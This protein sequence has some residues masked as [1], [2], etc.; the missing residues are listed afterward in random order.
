MPV[1][2]AISL[3]FRA[4]IAFTAWSLACHQSCGRCSDQP[5]LGRDTSRCTLSLS[6]TLWAS[7]INTALTDDVP[8]SMP[9]YMVCSPL[10]RCGATTIQDRE[11][12][13]V[14]LGAAKPTFCKA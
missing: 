7:S 6:T 8:T 1:T 12:R 11:T 14:A 10:E 9:T 2:A 3:A 13:R 5:G 4:A